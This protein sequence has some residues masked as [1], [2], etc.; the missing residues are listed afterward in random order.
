MLFIKQSIWRCC[1]SELLGPEPQPE[2]AVRL[3]AVRHRHLN[4]TADPDG[5]DMHRP[6]MSVWP[7]IDED[8]PP[9]VRGSAHDDGARCP[10]GM[11]PKMGDIA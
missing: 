2:L 5:K 10:D 8:M 7:A 9:A 11:P 4:L 1:A 3:D 6:D